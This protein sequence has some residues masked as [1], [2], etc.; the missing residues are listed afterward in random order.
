MN[1][2]KSCHNLV[3]KSFHKNKKIWIIN[4]IRFG[5][6][7][8]INFKNQIIIFHFILEYE[9]TIFY[10]IMIIMIIKFGNYETKDGLFN[11]V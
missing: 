2:N 3:K 11:G 1:S 9:M 10:H 7:E 6:Y 4:F 8:R 5:H